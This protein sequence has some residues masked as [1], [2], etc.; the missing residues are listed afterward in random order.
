MVS[1]IIY[2]Q[3]DKIMIKQLLG[4]KEV[5]IYTIASSLSGIF[6]ILIPPF[7]NSVYTKLIEL[8]KSNYEKYIK[9]YLNINTI[10]TQLYLVLAILSII[11]VK[12]IFPYVYNKEYEGAVSCYIILV[13]S[14][15]FKANGCLQTGH[16][17]L[18]K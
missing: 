6:A 14:I 1:F 10:F 11:V 17:T 7:Q 4:L 12:Y 9:I 13:I 15:F 5:G 3:I 2:C 16:M 8:Y 18:K